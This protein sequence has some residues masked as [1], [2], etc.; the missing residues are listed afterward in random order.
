MEIPKLASSL[1]LINAGLVGLDPKELTAQQRIHLAE[2]RDGAEGLVLHYMQ[3]FHVRLLL[4]LDPGPWKLEALRWI[5]YA[6][7]IVLGFY[8]LTLSTWWG[9]C[10]CALVA[11]LVGVLA[12]ELPTLP[13]RPS[14]DRPPPDS[15]AQGV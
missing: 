11:T 5:L 7:S 8:S 3:P 12:A 14:Q 9:E 2:V 6:I 10:L 1:K 4:E 15:D 13:R